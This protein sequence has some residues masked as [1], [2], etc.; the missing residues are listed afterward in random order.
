MYSIGH[1]AH[2]ELVERD[3]YSVF[4]FLELES[5]KERD[6]GWGSFSGKFVVIYIIEFCSLCLFSSVLVKDEISKGIK[7]VFSFVGFEF[8][9]DM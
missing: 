5:C 7:D 4:D 9:W 1:T 2:F 6:V 8:S 3:D